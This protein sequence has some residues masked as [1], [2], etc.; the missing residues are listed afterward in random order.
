MIRSCKHIETIDNPIDKIECDE[1]IRRECKFCKIFIRILKKKSNITDEII[2]FGEFK[3][4]RYID[5]D[6][7]YLEL[8][9][10]IFYK[11]IVIMDKINK[12]II[13]KNKIPL[14]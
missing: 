2:H 6:N 14:I 11:N 12:A 5:L 4:K 3:G 9:S 10:N 8:L 1:Y 13:Y 7:G